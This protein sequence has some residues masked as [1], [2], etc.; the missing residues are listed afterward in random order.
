MSKRRRKKK[1]ELPKFPRRQWE[2]GQAPRIEKPKKG[3]G[4]YDRDREKRLPEK[5]SDPFL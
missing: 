2:P 4:T 5:G 1:A 3:R